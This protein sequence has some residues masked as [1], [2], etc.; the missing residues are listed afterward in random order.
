MSSSKLPAEPGIYTL[1]VEVA[2]PVEVKVGKLGLISFHQG[3]YTYT[4]SALGGNVNL[5]ARVNRH[6]TFE[7]KKHWHVDYL[8][9]SKDTA[10]RAVVWEE[11]HLK[12]ECQISKSIEQAANFRTLIRGFGSSDCHNE[13]ASHLHYVLGLS[14]DEVISFVA[15]IYEWVFSDSQHIHILHT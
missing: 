4:G 13:C 6:L 7:K 10:V 3:L 11:T 2:Q 8:L 15:K 5:R 9:S 12:K 1:I 14:L